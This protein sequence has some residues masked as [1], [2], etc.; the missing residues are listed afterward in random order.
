MKNKEWIV[1]H[2]DETFSHVREQVVEYLSR[3]YTLKEAFELMDT[4]EQTTAM[5]RVSNSVKVPTFHYESLEESARKLKKVVLRGL[6]TAAFNAI[7]EEE[8]KLTSKP[9]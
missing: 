9:N 7:V 6:Y 4:F 2:A 5:Y 8:C 1:K 3:P